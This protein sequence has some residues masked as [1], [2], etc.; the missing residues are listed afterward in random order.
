MQD[1]KN[2]KDKQDTKEKKKLKHIPA[3]EMLPIVGG[4]KDPR[5]GTTIPTEEGVIAAKNFVEENQQ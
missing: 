4:K 3:Y 2:N 1:N 5:S